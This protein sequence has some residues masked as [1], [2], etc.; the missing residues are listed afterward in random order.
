MAWCLLYVTTFR[1]HLWVSWCFSLLFKAVKNPRSCSEGSHC[2][3]VATGTLRPGYTPGSCCRNLSKLH[4]M[5]F[6]LPAILTKLRTAPLL[7][8]VL[9]D[10]FPLFHFPCCCALS[11]PVT[12]RN[13][14]GLVPAA[15]ASKAGDYKYTTLL[16]LCGGPSIHGL[17]WKGSPDQ[18]VCLESNLIRWLPSWTKQAAEL[19]SKALKFLCRGI[20][21]S[22]DHYYQGS[23]L[24]LLED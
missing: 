8:Q 22:K 21:I 20:F 16:A 23:P 13:F 3:S 6:W 1:A 4:P 15:A 14:L 11:S 19:P 17:L 10:P 24:P 12:H 18:G 7:L 9:L 2:S 5:L